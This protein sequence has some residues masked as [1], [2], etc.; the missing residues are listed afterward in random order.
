MTRVLLDTT[1][2]LAALFDEPGA[3]IVRS[4]GQH[5]AVSAANYSEILATLT[6]RG[7]PLDTAEQVVCGLN[8]EVLAA[9]RAVAV[10]A[11]R[12][13]AL[14]RGLG[15][16]LADRLC[17]A[18]ASIHRLPVLTTDRKWTTIDLGVEVVVIGP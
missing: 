6:D 3:S 9:N 4:R 5:G 1:A 12:F 17:L 11:A 10:R 13:R 7:V 8:L 18:S 16:S 15:F 14:T 2:V